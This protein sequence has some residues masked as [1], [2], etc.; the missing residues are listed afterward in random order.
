[1][2]TS[3]SQHRIGYYDGTKKILMPMH[4]FIKGFLEFAF[5]LFL[6]ML[7]N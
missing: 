5:P 2:K 1:M 6:K 4:I 7:E 3:P